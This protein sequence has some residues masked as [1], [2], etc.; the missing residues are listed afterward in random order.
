M[1]HETKN[2]SLNE[3]IIKALIKAKIL[4]S[5]I[6]ETAISDSKW[7]EKTKSGIKIYLHE[8][9]NKPIGFMVIT[10]ANNEKPH[11]WLCGVIEEYR[12]VQSDGQIIIKELYKR[13]KTDYKNINSFTVA[14]YPEKFKNMLKW[15]TS[16]KYKII[17][18][19]DN[20]KIMY[21]IFLN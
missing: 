19:Y 21:E 4:E 20:G 17:K 9:E 6:F 15:I 8:T 12:G 13:F 7:E 18:E 14:S 2:S 16:Q 3:D 5:A 11:L 1:M 10:D